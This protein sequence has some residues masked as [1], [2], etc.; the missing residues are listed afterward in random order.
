[1]T[2]FHKIKM[3]TF[4]NNAKMIKFEVVLFHQVYHRVQK[5]IFL[6]LVSMFVCLLFVLVLLFGFFVFLCLVGR[7]V[8]LVVVLFVWLVLFVCFFLVFG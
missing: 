7:L 8:V 2:S 4:S 1:M 5:L 3:R 6:S